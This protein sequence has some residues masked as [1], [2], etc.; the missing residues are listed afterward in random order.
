[1]AKAQED[2]NS[3]LSDVRSEK[4]SKGIWETAAAGT[5]IDTH[6]PRA[7]F[8]IVLILALVFVTI[9]SVGML[10]AR[11]DETT[12][13]RTLA[14]SPVFFEE[15]GSFN[16]NVLD[17]SGTYFADHFA[18]RNQLV[19][20]NARVRSLFGA[21]P[22]DQV[23]IGQDGWLYYGGTLPD[24]LGQSALT[25][26]A[27][28]NIAHNLALAQEYT[29]SQGATFAFTLAPN[30]NTLYPEHM[31]YYYIRSTEQSN[32][33]RLSPILEELGVHYVNMFDVFEG[34]SGDWYLE[35]DSHWDNRGALLAAQ[36]I[37]AAVGHDALSLTVDE[38]EMRSDFAGDLENMLYPSGAALD[39][40]WY[41]ADVNDAEG[42]SGS[43]WSYVQGANVTDDWVVTRA[44][45]GTGSLLV[46]RD[47]FGNALLPLLSSTY[48]QGV[49]SK[50]VPYNLPVMVECRA[51]AVVIERAERHLSYIAE[52]P[53]I[54][55]NPT[56]Q[57]GVQLPNRVEKGQRTTFEIVENGPYWVAQG[58]I[59]ES[60]I[61]D[62]DH[63][64]L[65]V[66]DR[67]GSQVVYD[68]FWTSSF[69]DTG[70]D[71]SDT[72]FM[73]YL[74]KGAFEVSDLTFSVYSDNVDG[75]T[76]LGVFHGVQ[77]R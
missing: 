4:L 41:F 55:P 33:E 40:N 28:R 10:W 12:E 67:D 32:A 36:E 20:A 19:A 74:P 59:D 37:L 64:Y 43:S 63:I 58:T 16:W 22:T 30:K 18:Y 24:Y 45:A 44:K 9:P 35:K 61:A 57:L 25:D 76:C 38:A 13:N 5:Y 62:E 75:I 66:N 52:N 31:P 7:V 3:M 39:Q 56:V 49:F 48:G 34:A 8:A 27:L 29:E 23:V 21:S 11:T 47:S 51:D 71:L 77:P 65:A 50:L 60:V 53:P 6:V 17:D 14:E 15:D 69:D 72:G 42:M 54:M 1:M 2:Q 70:M 73:V 68:C 26:R 46:F